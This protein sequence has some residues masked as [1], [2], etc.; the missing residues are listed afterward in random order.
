MAIYAEGP[1]QYLETPA[2][3]TIVYLMDSFNPKEVN[4]NTGTVLTDF[5]AS[6]IDPDTI[7]VV[8]DD[9]LHTLDGGTDDMRRHDASTGTGNVQLNSFEIGDEGITVRQIFNGYEDESYGRTE[10]GTANGHRITSFDSL[11]ITSFT[12]G[13]ALPLPSLGQT[14]SQELDQCL[15]AVK[16]GVV[17]APAFA[18]DDDEGSGTKSILFLVAYN[19]PGLTNSLVW[20]LDNGST[21]A[22]GGRRA[23]RGADAAALVLDDTYVF[24]WMELESDS[25]GLSEPN[26]LFKIDVGA[27]TA[28]E[29]EIHNVGA[30]EIAANGDL[31]LSE[32]T[33]SGGSA[34][35]VR[36]DPSDMSFIEEI[37]TNSY[38]R[39]EVNSNGTMVGIRSSTVAIIDL[40][41]GTET[42]TYSGSTFAIAETLPTRKPLP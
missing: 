30:M 17:Y 1:F 37:N 35:T 6:A 41:T 34:R 38:Q 26:V 5:G 22:G 28:T 10:N 21:Y 25:L 33:T 7:A 39:L 40:A 12:E 36:R 19:T 4:L 32:I 8:G 42:H 3:D 9:Q 29:E 23:N 20:T 31:I 2:Q 16:P 27:G 15:F 13:S 18:I 24:L 11:D 14:D